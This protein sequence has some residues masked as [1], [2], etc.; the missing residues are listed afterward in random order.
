MQPRSLVTD[1]KDRHSLF[2]CE[3][4]ILTPTLQAQEME[5]VLSAEITARKRA[6]ERLANADERL[7]LSK[8]HLPPPSKSNSV[9]VTL[10][11][12]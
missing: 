11:A 4:L 1:P 8:C 2:M 9:A 10:Q 6:F 7:D 12:Q 3:S 5:D